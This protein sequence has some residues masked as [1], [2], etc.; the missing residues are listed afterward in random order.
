MKASRGIRAE[1]A[2]NPRSAARWKPKRGVV[3]GAPF[4]ENKWLAALKQP[5]RRCDHLATDSKALQS[6]ANA[7]GAEDEHVIQPMW[8]VKHCVRIEHTPDDFTTTVGDK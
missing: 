5:Q 4:E 2:T 7:D 3:G 6:R 8:G 1:G